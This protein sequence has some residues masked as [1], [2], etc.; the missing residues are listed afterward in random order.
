G[1]VARPS[2]PPI[3]DG[4]ICCASIQT[5]RLMRGVDFQIQLGMLILETGN[6]GQQALRCKP[7]RRGK[8]YGAARTRC[9]DGLY[10]LSKQVETLAQRLVERQTLRSQNQAPGSPD[11]QGQL[12]RCL[13][14]AHLMTDRRGRHKQFCSRVFCAEMPGRRLKG[15]QCC[16]RW[17]V[18]HSYR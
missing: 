7:W 6:T 5:H 13:Q 3:A 16:K 1:D 4:H 11:E 18:T 15:A 9:A 8:R 14:A 2:A 10:G 17:K 12:Q